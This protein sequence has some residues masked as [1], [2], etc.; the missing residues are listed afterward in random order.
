MTVGGKPKTSSVS[1]RLGPTATDK[2]D[3][4]RGRPEAETKMKSAPAKD[5]ELPRKITALECKVGG[6]G[7]QGRERRD[8]ELCRGQERPSR[9]S[10]FKPRGASSPRLSPSPR[11]R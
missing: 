2:D 10:E 5:D 7:A 11:R 1:P 8:Q 4:R 6:R 9:E 3:R